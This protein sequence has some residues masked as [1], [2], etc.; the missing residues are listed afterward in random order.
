MLNN[1]Q[2]NQATKEKAD[3]ERTETI[4]NFDELDDGSDPNADL[5]LL[6]DAV[7]TMKMKSEIQ[8][9]VSA[10]QNDT[11]TDIATDSQP[12]Q[13]EESFILDDKSLPSFLWI[14]D[15][16]RE[17]AIAISLHHL[18]ILTD[19]EQDQP[20]LWSATVRLIHAL[21]L[22]ELGIDAMDRLDFE[23]QFKGCL[24]KVELEINCNQLPTIYYFEDKSLQTYAWALMDLDFV[25][26]K[27]IGDYV[28]FKHSAEDPKPSAFTQ[29]LDL[30]D[31]IK[32]HDEA[33]TNIHKNLEK[34]LGRIQENSDDPYVQEVFA[35]FKADQKKLENISLNPEFNEFMGFD[36]DDEEMDE[37][38]ISFMEIAVM[39]SQKIL[40]SFER[41]ILL[42]LK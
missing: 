14:R 36:R 5:H 8:V 27:K 22:D 39:L 38:D 30:D 6:R 13:F 4:M 28:F 1:T 11:A 41:L 23:K 33:H 17:E 7:H 35:S 16:L 3:A 40:F 26:E 42:I 10:S 34:A 31:V 25:D 29:G 37:T 20:K 32:T 9:Q 24:I 2:N 21:I 19:F 15:L 18:D 12:K